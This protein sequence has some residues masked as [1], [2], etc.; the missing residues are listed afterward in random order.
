MKISVL[1][2]GTEL[3]IGQIANRNGQWI[4][5]QFK[6]LGVPSAMHLV[7]P[8]EKALIL[9]SLKFCAEHS[10]H[11]FITGGLGPTSDDFTRD[12]IT[13]WTGLKTFWDEASW[14]HIQDRLNSRGMVAKE[15]QKQQ[16]Y[17]PEGAKVLTNRMGTANAFAL[18]YQGKE[19]YVLPGPPR[20][21]EAIWQDHI[22]ARM[23]EKTRH[24]DHEVTKS[25]DT[26]GL[27]ESDIAELTEKA[28]VGCP[29]EKA[30]RVHLPF[31]EFKLS[32]PES[33]KDEAQQWAEKVEL[34]IG[35]YTLLRDGAEASALLAQKLT[36]QKK[37]FI[38]DEIPKSFLL[39]RLFPHC[40]Q[41]LADKKLNFMTEMPENLDPE[42][43]VLHLKD[44]GGGTAKAEWLRKGQNQSQSLLSPFKS[45][46][47][48]EREEQ[49]FAEMAMIF[50]LNSIS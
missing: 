8:D 38:C 23:K 45:P 4:S 31:V 16:C 17:F 24:L 40:K 19:I 36:S 3:T 43:L 41:L 18:Q 7:V 11:I 49:F 35:S 5:R 20:E 42:S 12:V 34:A 32:Y 37:V 22:L 50:W 28:L 26:I 15:I 39:N 44:E 25:W 48:K 2:I 47:L 33:R 9:S 21:I 14:Q 13:E 6:S 27:G 29:F 1:S 46:L 30:Y 10:D